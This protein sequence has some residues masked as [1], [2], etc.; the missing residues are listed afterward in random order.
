MTTRVQVGGIVL[1]LG[2]LAE[3]PH[4]GGWELWVEDADYDPATVPFVTH[5]G[6]MRHA[7][8][9][10]YHEQQRKESAKTREPKRPSIVPDTTGAETP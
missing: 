6:G 7:R 10:S 8:G 9:K 3:S 5:D 4:P 1:C 2:R